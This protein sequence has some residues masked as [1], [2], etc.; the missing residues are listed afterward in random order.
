[1]TDAYETADTLLADLA[2][3]YALQLRSAKHACHYSRSSNRPP[4]NSVPG[5]AALEPLL[6]KANVQWTTFADWQSLE[7]FEQVEVSSSLVYELYVAF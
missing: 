1:M 6:R 3:K 4:T 7:A 2:A 5:F